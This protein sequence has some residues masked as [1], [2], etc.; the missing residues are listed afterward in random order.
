MPKTRG[1]TLRGRLILAFAVVLAMMLILTV[2][3]IARV[4]FIDQTL[5][6][7]SEDNAVKQRQ[8]INM[9]GS[10]HDR[11]IA[12]RDLVLVDDRR[13]HE[14]LVTL[15][16]DLR[17][18]YV[19]A[20]DALD[21]GLS[22][23]EATERER[24]LFSDIVDTT[25][26]AKPLVASIIEETRRGNMASATHTLKQEAGPLYVRWLNEINAFIDYQEAE[27]RALSNEVYEVAG[28]F[29]MLMIAMFVVSLLVAAVVIGLLLRYLNRSI[30]GEPEEMK[31]FVSAIAAGDLT[32]EA[33]TRHPESVQGSVIVMRDRLRSIVGNIREGAGTINMASG[34]IATGNTDL[35]KRTEE[36]AANLEETAASMEEITSTVRQNADNARQADQL[37]NQA[38]ENA[39]KGGEVVNDVVRRMVDIRDG[40]RKM[41]EIINVID[42]IAFQ[43]NIL[44]LNAA[45]EAARAGEQGRGFAV[46]ATEVRSLAQRSAS[47]AKDIKVLIEESVDSITTGSELAN[48]AGDSTKE[49]VAS[50]RKVSDIIGEISAASDE[51]T[52]GIEEVNQAVSQMDQ[53]TQQNAALV[54]E[55]AAAAESLQSQ[56]E[57]LEASVKLFKV[58]EGDQ[59]ATR[60]AAKLRTPSGAAARPEVRKTSARAEPRQPPKSVQ[61]NDDDWEEF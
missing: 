47:A 40:S 14:Q 26:E 27:S 16:R 1:L 36:Q 11:A 13:E 50:I 41:A 10:V 59:S 20:Y 46:V 43:T 29:Q 49:I 18:D 42:G 8:A 34:E 21:S 60:Q 7:I 57:E 45:V 37:S 52:T 12:V 56:A 28:S 38:T 33:E 53:A 39:E 51:Q 15:I 3:G 54:E 32:V 58:S 61:E 35:S 48:K 30:G 25:E 6:D 9:R 4:D 31:A 17:A 24:R 23:A 19:K 5:T 2:V 44:A 22:G 55:S